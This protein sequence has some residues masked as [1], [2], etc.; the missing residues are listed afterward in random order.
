LEERFYRARG[1]LPAVDDLPWQED[2]FGA[3]SAADDLSSAAETARKA[4]REAIRKEF[5]TRF[6]R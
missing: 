2:Y 1:Y 4:E 6:C 5:L 3:K